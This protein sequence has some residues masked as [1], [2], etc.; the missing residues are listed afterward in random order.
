MDKYKI[1]I[2]N[3]TIKLII[4]AVITF[5]F[6]NVTPSFADSNEPAEN[7]KPYNFGSQ[8]IND[9]VMDTG[10]IITSHTRWTGTDWLYTGLTIGTTIGLY[11][12][13]P[14]IQYFFMTLNS[15]FT[16]TV[17]SVA[18]TF[19]DPWYVIPALGTTYILA[20]IFPDRKLRKT[21]L[22]SL[23][24]LLISGL[25]VQT[26]KFTFH[27]HRPDQYFL[28]DQ[29]DGP[30]FSS[31]NLSFPSGH[32]AVAFSVLTVFASEY[33]DEPGVAPIAYTL[34]TLVMLSRVHDFTHWSSDAF[35]AGAI[36]FFTAKAIVNYHK[37]SEPE[38]VAL[39][40]LFDDKITGILLTY[41]F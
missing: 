20:E 29:F 5:Q 17:S 34:A 26:L 19:G 28:Y 41:K 24:S 3:I 2:K 30:S 31:R 38:K 35:F 10:K 15:P 39:Y 27:R 23:E 33:A 13:D 6:S 32:T 7:E 40:P 4:I 18:T 16:R 11:F 25:F 22:L 8:Y 12:A 21:T 9:I 14:H 1:H 36:G 37:E